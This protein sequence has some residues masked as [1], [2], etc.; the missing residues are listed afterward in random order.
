MLESQ[1]QEIRV[2][3]ADGSH[4]A[5][6]G[7]RGAGPGEFVDANGIMVDPEGRLW[8]PDS[9]LSRMSVFDPD[10]GFLE[11]HRF[12]SFVRGWVWTG[13]MTDDGRIIKDESSML[14]IIDDGIQVDSVLLPSESDEP[15]VP[16][17]DPFSFGG[18]AA[19]PFH[20]VPLDHIGRSGEMWSAVPIGSHYRVKRWTP[21]GDTTLAVTVERAP[22]PVTAF[23]RDS[24]IADIK[25]HLEQSWGITTEQDWSRI[26][27]TKPPVTSLF[28]SLKGNLWVR[29]PAL[30][31]IPT[32]DVLAPDGAYLGT[33]VTPGLDTPFWLDPVV[34]GDTFW[35]IVTDDLDVPHVVRARVVFG[36]PIGG[37]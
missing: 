12:I 13:A 15:Y 2:F 14:R 25:E 22:V 21:G 32:Y 35:A 3:A 11:S 30:D 17:N 9:R 10:D 37:R 19:V 31:G 5:T 26:H 6:H 33:A 29:V 1:A 28:N 27:A 20:A 8:V 18:M 34:R 36:D 16:T 23:E 4:L 7:R 24:V